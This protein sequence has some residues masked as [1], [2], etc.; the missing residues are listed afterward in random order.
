MQ[1]NKAIK[2]A[3]K[4]QLTQNWSKAYAAMAFLLMA[5]LCIYLAQQLISS[6]LSTYG[7]TGHS[8]VDISAIT[9]LSDLAL[10]FVKLINTEDFIYSL[11]ITVFF[12]ILRFLIISPME[13]GETK[14]YYSVAKGSKT[15]LS[16]MFAYYQSNQSY[17]SL[18]LFKIGLTLRGILYGVISFFAAIAA[19]SLTIYQL[20]VYSLSELAADRNKAILYLA[21]TVFLV[22]LGACLYA[23]LML[24]FFLS[25]YLFADIKKFDGGI[26][27]INNCFS[28]SKELMAG[29]TVRVISLVLSFIPAIL[30][31]VFI[32]PIFYVF[33]HMKA[34]LAVLAHDI[35]RSGNQKKDS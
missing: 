28:K 34:S 4:K 13:L 5:S 30:S 9:N 32:F 11:A 7:I 18:L 25:S 1:T 12:L 22:L 8:D 26:R 3:A 35:I 19:M 16:K 17:I 27:Q 33:P 15:Y 31:C 20:S 23:L 10:T 2:S 6:L 21:V 24:K 29:D 14:W